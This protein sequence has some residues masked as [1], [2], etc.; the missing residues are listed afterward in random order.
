M[1]HPIIWLPQAAEDLQEISDYIGQ[2]S[3]AYADSMIERIINAVE[4]L[5]QFPLMGHRV[6][7]VRIK[8]VELRELSARPY[9]IVYRVRDDRVVV[10]AIVHGVRLL[11]TAL[12][13]R[14]RG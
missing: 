14:R 3:P 9:R 5:E 4:R 8:G 6:L 2:S 13:G 7:D 11:R 12:R 1:A 10:L